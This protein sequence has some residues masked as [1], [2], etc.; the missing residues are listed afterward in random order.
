MNLIIQPDSGLTPVVQAIKRAK[1]RV[2]VAI[3]R[4]DSKDVEK[5][6][7]TAVQRGV[8]ARVL[9]AHTNSGG[10]S[11]L[12]KLEQR[13]L[14]SGVT[15]ARTGD[16]FVRYHGKFMVTDDRLYVFGFNFTK[17]DTLKSR[18]FGISTRDQSAI[19]EALALFEADA[20]RQPFVP[21]RTR[22]VVSPEN[23]RELLTKFVKGAKQQLLVYDTNLQDPAF[24]KLLK[25]Q[26][27]SGIDVRVIGKCK[28]SNPIIVRPLKD[29]RLHVR[30][31][32]RDGSQAFVGSQSLRRLE[33]DARREV[34]VLITNRSV[35][36][37]VRDVF[38]RDWEE[39]TPKKEEKKEEK[40]GE[41]E[42][43]K[44]DL[45]IAPERRAA[46]G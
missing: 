14:E 11:R 28:N 18:S 40:K 30:A 37:K 6:L 24:L 4:L 10:E 23:A 38:E 42:E 43:K 33:L 27:S 20:T 15:V 25:Q 5:A 7:A 21:K 32:V 35:A 45:R 19:N 46:A 22:L 31:I 13:L 2:D 1:R 8:R 39:S 29:T 34:G 16:E 12:R 36:K 26:A 9:V 3:F 17:V 44:A 41:K